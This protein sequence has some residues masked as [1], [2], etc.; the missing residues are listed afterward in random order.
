MLID[1]HAH[2]YLE[3]FALDIDEV[4]T[5]ALVRK[6]EKILL[7]N[8][9]STSLNPL[10]SLTKRYPEICLPMIG[11]HPCSVGSNYLSELKLLEQALDKQA[12]VAIGEIGI[13]LYWDKS[14][15]SEQIDAFRIQI[16][17]AK[18][19]EIPIVIHSRD[20]INETLRIVEEMKDDKLQGVFHCFGE[21][22]TEAKRIVD[23]GF[24]MGIGGVYTYKKSIEL[25][26]AIDVLGLKH[27]ILETDAPYLAPVPFRG[28]RNESSYVYNIAMCL[29]ENLG[30][31]LDEV[32]KI[33]SDN[34]IR[35]FKL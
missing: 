1:T 34:A 11:L 30:L 27:V 24:H 21:S 13:D 28:K 7:P 15:H 20:A 6:V 18:E 33:T 29:A 2:L 19:R 26:E 5:N 14:F 23:M 17:W 3:Q 4:I 16:D 10:L 31:T 35:L 12:I 9:D 25:R 8:I 22:L 32:E